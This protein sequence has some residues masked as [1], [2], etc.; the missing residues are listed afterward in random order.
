MRK[1]ITLIVTLTAFTFLGGVAYAKGDAFISRVQGKA[2]IDSDG[3]SYQAVIGSPLEKGDIIRTEKG[4]QVDVS[5]NKLA[6]FRLL[7]SSDMTLEDIEKTDMKLKIT[8]GNVILNLQQLPQDTAFAMDTPSAVAAVRGTQFWGRVDAP[9]PGA[10]V[11]TLAVREGAVSVLVKSS[12][13]TVTLNPGQA[14]D[15]SLQG[16]PS[17]PREALKAE[18]G[19]MAQASEI[20]TSL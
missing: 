15:I 3:R 11:T 8:K 4:A 10:S 6:G 1:I 13:E 16:G 19:A 18:M 5:M 17:A 20:S 2:A 12:G 14:L 7:A 9:S